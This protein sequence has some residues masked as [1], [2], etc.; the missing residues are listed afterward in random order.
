ME[1][2]KYP[3]GRFELTTDYSSEKVEEYIRTLEKFTPLFAQIAL[4][5]TSEQLHKSYRQGG[6]NAIQLIHHVADS[7]MN[8]YIRF[9]LAL[10]ETNPII[11]SFDENKWSALCDACEGGISS[12]LQILSGL[13]YRWVF[14]LR[15]MTENDWHKTI[16]HPEHQ[17]EQ[18]LY[19]LLQYYAWHAEHHLAHL[20]IIKEI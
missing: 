18:D 5:L 9:K 3:I 1:H 6:W 13:H 10:T 14:L 16:F 7:H 4:E 2:L 20:K 15:N 19:F 17:K 12:S 8:S 11:K